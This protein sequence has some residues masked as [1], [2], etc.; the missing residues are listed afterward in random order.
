M[1]IGAS[2]G[3]PP[4]NQTHGKTIFRGVPIN[5]ARRGFSDY[6]ELCP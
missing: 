4:R 2:P 1:N 5:T 3:R 6:G